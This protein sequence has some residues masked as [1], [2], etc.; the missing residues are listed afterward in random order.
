MAI[1]NPSVTTS[2]LLREKLS[3]VHCDNAMQDIQ[4]SLLRAVGFACNRVWNSAFLCS[5]ILFGDKYPGAWCELCGRCLLGE[6]WRCGKIIGVLTRTTVFWLY[7]SFSIDKSFDFPLLFRFCTLCTHKE[8]PTVLSQLH[9]SGAGAASYCQIYRTCSGVYMVL[10]SS[11]MGQLCRKPCINISLEIVQYISKIKPVAI[12]S[13]RE[14]PHSSV[15]KWSS[16][17]F[18]MTVEKKL[19]TY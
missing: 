19:C 8:I 16:P 3:S 12:L 17:C 14:S 9:V 11:A 4:H 6:G 5:I 13:V 10:F 2:F 1:S 15:K 7:C 18:K